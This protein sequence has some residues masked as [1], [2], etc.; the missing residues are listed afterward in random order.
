MFENVYRL[1][2]VNT[3]FAR[4]VQLL[5][6]QANEYMPCEVTQFSYVNGNCEISLGVNALRYNL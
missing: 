6:E 4:K 2:L 1:A 3:F 5:I